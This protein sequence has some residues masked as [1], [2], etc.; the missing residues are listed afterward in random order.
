MKV[1][2]PSGLFE[3]MGAFETKSKWLPKCIDNLYFILL[4]CWEISTPMRKKYHR[5]I[6]FQHTQSSSGSS[7]YMNCKMYMKIYIFSHHCYMWEAPSHVTVTSPGQHTYD[8]FYTRTTRVL[9]L[10]K[11]S[12]CKQTP[13]NKAPSSDEAAVS[14]NWELGSSWPHTAC[15]D[16]WGCVPTAH[17]CASHEA[18]CCRSLGT[19]CRTY[20]HYY[21]SACLLSSCKQCLCSGM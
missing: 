5:K 16:G 20:L 15:P 18:S 17:M 19:E 6:S 1:Y 10:Q 8:I 4:P 14:T 12:L 7:S 9:V 13:T 21:P 11:C 3:S 2:C